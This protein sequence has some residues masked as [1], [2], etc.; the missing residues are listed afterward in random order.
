MARVE[1]IATSDAW[2]A[3]G[4]Q[5][6]SHAFRIGGWT[7]KGS[8]AGGGVGCA[9]KGGRGRCQGTSSR[10]GASAGAAGLTQGSRFVCVEHL[11]IV[12]EGEKFLWFLFLS[13]A[14]SLGSES[15]TQIGLISSLGNN[16]GRSLR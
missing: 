2:K 13:D 11:Q 9:G 4:A 6:C 8:G 12:V 10:G 14:F 3:V 1:Q 5:R 16:P 15:D 7:W